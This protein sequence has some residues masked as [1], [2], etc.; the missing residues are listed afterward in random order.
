[1]DAEARF[2][3]AGLPS[4]AYR[5]QRYVEDGSNR[6]YQDYMGEPVK[7]D[8][9]Q[10]RTG[11]EV[12]FPCPEEDVIEGYIRD[13]NGAGLPGVEVDA[14]THE[15]LHW[16]AKTDAN[17]FY[18]VLGAG[19]HTFDLYLRHPDYPTAVLKQVR[20][21]RKDAHATLYRGGAVSG[22]VKDAV[23]GAPLD[24]F[25]VEI[26]KLLPSNAGVAYSDRD[27]GQFER[28]ASPG[29][30]AVK[31]VP[32]G[33]ATVRVAAPNHL[34]TRVHDVRIDDGKSTDGLEFLLERA[35]VIEG[36]V[37]CGGKPFEAEQGIHV[38]CLSDPDR[39]V[40]AGYIIQ[41]GFYRLDGLAPGEYA[42]NAW[43]RGDGHH[44]DKTITVKA[45]A[46]E[47]VRA[48]FELEYPPAMT[49]ATSHEAPVKAEAETV[50]FEVP[51][52]AETGQEWFN[53]GISVPAGADL[54]ITATGTATW[55][56]QLEKVS[57]QGAGRTPQ[58]SCGHP[59]EFLMPTAPCG[60]LVGKVGDS[61]TPFFVGE[62][63]TIKAESAGALYLGINDRR[64]HF[65]D[66]DGAFKVTV[67]IPR[68]G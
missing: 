60:G 10:T 3:T 43:A 27:T 7:V 26:E 46:G 56:Q 47:T 42:V 62:H 53:T 6:Y 37:H 61:G 34:P 64:G 4:G 31:S 44:T 28:G 9:G 5:F 36:T 39:E 45:A 12:V 33:T 30:F 50:S 65:A 58:A 55:D 23:S 17:G 57:P 38:D 51:A 68:S 49:P 54:D 63:G 52:K 25:R 13:A 11:V 16:G 29:T 22:V 8:A 18:R 1:V 15:G 21:V 66:N 41:N 40:S 24:D 59:E 19:D 35:A 20:A 14:L 2:R 48:D 67:V 32:P